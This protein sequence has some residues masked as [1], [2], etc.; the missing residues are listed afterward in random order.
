MEGDS[1]PK[2][3]IA[4]LTAEWFLSVGLQGGGTPAQERLSRTVEPDMARVRAVLSRSFDLVD[5]GPLSTR[6][7]A[8]A[9]ARRF[10]AEEAGL[11]I[12]VDVQWC[13]DA[14]LVTLLR[15]LPGLPILLW[16]Y[17][18]T[19]RL[20]R[21][22]STEELFR[23]SG[24][25][26]FLQGSAP[27]RRMGRDFSY[28]FGAPGDESV[29]RD[30]AEYA[31]V[32]AA[33]AALPHLRAGQV[34]SRC[35]GMTGTYV[36]EMRLLAG[37]GVQLVPLSYERL[38]REAASLDAGTV[39]A[40]SRRVKGMCREVSV[41]E[42]SLAAASRVSL[43]LA[44]LAEK[45]DIGVLSI[46]DLH[47]ELHRLL[48]TRPCLWVP[49]LAR[50]GTVVAMENDLFSAL[51]M[52]LAMRIGGSSPMYTEIFT[53]DR[54]ENCLLFGHAGMQD[55]A[56][57]GENPI[58]LVPDAEYQ[59]VDEVEGA[60]LQ[61]AARPGRI[62]AVSLFADRDV[63][64]IACV[65]GEVL[66]QSDK[67]AGFAHALVRIDRPLEA[68]FEEAGRLGMTQHFAVTY[69]EVAPGLARLARVLGM[70]FVEL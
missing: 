29:D 11:L 9:A 15:E 52:W 1:R 58:D 68:F 35:E 5:P 59:A 45:E 37:L 27:L 42:P 6:A 17:V 16:C 50:R 34:G 39:D 26:G 13:E 4:L 10:R 24:P 60:W 64:R 8:M 31:R 65:K 56:L 28:L 54:E 43:A 70:Q 67:L 41:S 12:V 61:F 33:A 2:A 53:F 32:F 7:Q 51:G 19:P 23:A 57:A 14:P 21:R 62:T 66:P 47:P 49:E 25:V 20:P 3:G 22:M 30:L 55:T 63:Y 46:E 40:F 18:P 44:A 69:D 38:S 48:K 36:E